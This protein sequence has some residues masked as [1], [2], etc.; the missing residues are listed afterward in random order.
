MANGVTL[1]P[2]LKTFVEVWVE[3]GVAT[4]AARASGVPVREAMRSITLQRAA[5]DALAQRLLSIA[6]KALSVLEA[7][8][9]DPDAPAAVKRLAAADILDRV[10]L[11]SQTALHLAK[12]IESLSEMPARDLRALVSRLE[13][14]LF[15]RAKPVRDLELTATRDA[16]AESKPLGIL[17]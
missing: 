13:T 17:D 5:R 8:L 3:T 10:G 6:P 9:D 11:V 2:E 7:L 4:E 12:P 14:E 16:P 1:S 15:A